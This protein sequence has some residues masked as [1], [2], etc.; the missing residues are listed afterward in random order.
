MRCVCRF[1][2]RFA[3]G[4]S[5]VVCLAFIFTSL[6]ISPLSH[7]ELSASAQSGQGNNDKA[8]K[9]RPAP[10]KKGAP[11]FTLPVL[12]GRRREGA[13][14]QM[15]TAMP[16]TVR[17]K[18]KALTPGS[19]SASARARL[20]ARARS[21]A[22]THHVM[23][24]IPDPPP[25]AA[26]ISD[27]VD[28]V[29]QPGN[30]LLS[31]DATWSLSLLNLPGRAG[32]D[33]GLGLSYSSMIWT[34]SGS[35][36][37]FDDD[38]GSPSPG[39]RLGFSTIQGLFYDSQ[40]GVNAYL[41]LTSSGRRVELRQ[42]GT[43]N[44]YAA[45]DS[46]YLQLTDNSAASPSELI[47]A[48]TDGT[49][50]SH[51]LKANGWQAK[52]IR[53][54]NGN[55][56]S[57]V[58]DWQ[59]DIQT[60]T[61]TLG[62]VIYF[63]YD[64][65]A[66]LYSI[67]QNWNGSPHTLANFS[68]GS[69]LTMDVSGFTGAAVVGAYTGESLPVLRGVGL[70]DGSFYSFDY[71][72]VAEVTMIRSYRSD[73][74]QQ[75]YAAFDYQHFANDCSR[76][77]QTRVWADNWSDLNGV[78]H[79]VTTTFQTPAAGV[80]Q[81]V[82]HDSTIY[83][84]YY[85]SGWQRGLVT[86][87]D[88]WGRSDPGNLASPV[89]LQKW[90]T[91]EWHQD[92]ESV[93]YETNPRVTETIVSDAG[94]NNRRTKIAYTSYA[95]PSDIYEF[96]AN[97]STV[98]RR[99]HTDYQLDASYTNL[100]I[101]GLPAAH[102]VCDGAQAETPCGDSSS[103]LLAKTSYQYDEVST[104]NQGGPVQHDTNFGAG[105]QW[106]GNL[107]LTRRHNVNNLAQ[108]TNTAI[109]YNTA[110]SAISITDA[111]DHVSSI[112][113]TDS[114]SD[115]AS[116]NTYAYPTT[117]IDGGG[118][119]SYVQYNYDFG[120][121]TAVQTP[122]PNTTANTAGPV[123]RIFYDSIGR[124]HQVLAE[125]NGAST[126]YGY[127]T[128]YVQVWS[129]V[130][131]AGDSYSGKVF[132]GLGRVIVSESIHPGSSGGY[133]AQLTRYDAM[134]RVKSQSNPTEINGSYVPSGDDLYNSATDQG[135]YRFASQTYDWKGRPLETI[136]QDGT[137]KYASYD[138]CGCAGGEVVTLTDEV[139]RQQ[140]IYSDILSRQWK[141][142][143]LNWNGSVYS[144]TTKRFNALDQANRIRQYVGSAAFPEP[145][146][147]G[148]GYQSTTMTYDGYGRLA[149]KHV[150]EHTAGTA[151]VYAYNDDDTIQSV[152]DARGASATYGYNNNRHL[153]N[154]IHY[155]APS[156]IIVPSAVSFGYDAASNRTSMSDG[157]GSLN[158]HY[159]QLSRM[160]WEERTITGLPGSYRLSYGYNLAGQLTSLAEPSQF[161]ASVGYQH[162]STGRL[163]AVN[164]SGYTYSVFSGQTRTEVPITTLASNIQYRA[165]GYMKNM[166]DGNG[167]NSHF[168]YN[169]RLLPSAYT[170]SNLA[171][172]SSAMSWNYDYY[173]DGNIH[174]AYDVT[175]NL[176]D[177]AYAFDHVARLTESYS[178]SEARGG[179]TPDGPYRE[180]SSYD[181]WN[182]QLGRTGRWWQLNLPGA[183]V[184]SY[185]NNRRAGLPYD[186]SGRVISDNLGE[187]VFDAR[188]ARVLVTAGTVG[189]GQTGNPLQPA[190]EDASM[191]DGNGQI[192]KR[193]VTTRDETLVGGGP[194]TYIS[195]VSATTYYLRSSVLGNYVI[196]E[197]N[198]QGNKDK[199]YVYAG[200]ER[201]AEHA[202]TPW[203]NTITWQHKNPNTGSWIE[204]T[205][206]R[207]PSRTEVDSIGRDVG[208]APPQV[209]NL[210]D[211]PPPPTRSPMYLEN[212]GGQTIEAELGMQL[213]EDIYINKI[214]DKGAGPGQGGFTGDKYRALMR[215]REFQ[216]M[217]GAR[218]LFGMDKMNAAGGLGGD[219]YELVYD[220]YA[221][222]VKDSGEGNVVGSMT[223]VGVSY[224]RLV[225]GSGSPQNPLT[226]KEKTFVQNGI[227]R[228]NQLARRDDCRNFVNAVLQ[229]AAAVVEARWWATSVKPTA[230]NGVYPGFNLD[231]AL[232]MYQSALNSGF[233]TASGQSG[234][235]R[236][237]ITF[238]NTTPTGNYGVSWNR[239]FFGLGADRAG[240]HTLHEA[241]H[242][243]QGFDD[244]TLANAARF[245]AG[246]EQL[247]F[248]TE[249]D[250]GGAASRDFNRLLGSTDYCG[251]R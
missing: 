57:I 199:G 224:Y 174:H 33:L 162:D 169:T 15:R 34:R 46:S 27:R 103:S 238:G 11:E 112:S 177:R 179:T 219:S 158:Y 28:P 198:P 82:A 182:N 81:M 61:D 64:E 121:K 40:A 32:L 233:V 74:V 216:L 88:V 49:Q 102:Y 186:A 152:T 203:L 76:L 194:Q 85:G 72:I 118:F 59:G 93:S 144:T 217:S 18:K 2:Q 87:S 47:L 50:I 193:A 94:G 92:N 31:R 184:Y 7:V 19:R 191:F 149:N 208:V 53:D 164:G 229:R 43:S 119:S 212:V 173:A 98:L 20:N 167:V 78:P 41:L 65:N 16:S 210:P 148:S 168:D 75:A 110:G 38:N 137:V 190:E 165:W 221:I 45:G 80:Y 207:L 67:T 128:Y 6:A 55:Y 35:S 245:V 125:S 106:R 107:T 244:K 136:N 126:V 73:N 42:V 135:G 77:T 187:H 29:N 101:I 155:A 227:N 48:T 91:S 140:K 39:F 60:I 205:M 113:Y 123:Q 204:A 116:H 250:P 44:V 96:D 97:G 235:V 52:K 150:P 37:Y 172:S 247:D 26:A 145:E 192:T 175:N 181:V 163:T 25:V 79:E 68:W 214:F 14:P 23:R 130:N 13:A 63:N 70:P 36:I 8:R 239:E 237:G 104:T 159:D 117:I 69:P 83:R 196:D 56:I 248:S 108:Y 251:N 131:Q 89:I 143:I 231:K 228:A 230:N 129:S 241:L 30:G 4:I 141:T 105:F 1:P 171:G 189:G 17:S 211:P 120:G 226:S 180:T 132:D 197:I 100:R 176:F 134:G 234:A 133:L 213:Y 242:Q 206:D 236:D 12:D 109:S 5:V 111:Q 9:V 157:S 195:Q 201:L 153:V 240:F 66:N 139:G 86:R 71:N 220:S 95:L 154:E 232:S 249:V 99:T 21:A 3:R 122:Q 58:N 246:E 151:T 188:G 200:G 215:V 156:G 146:T 222:N 142:E 138:G 202:T 225:P 90:T 115:G 209:I 160:D 22:R 24:V 114:F 178:G 166:D 10:P 183:G 243:F 161:G 218:F 84:E 127:G 185:A 147:E 170:L 51:E 62:R 54:R 223:I 124:V